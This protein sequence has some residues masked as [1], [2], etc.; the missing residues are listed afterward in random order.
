V[1]SNQDEA[2][3]YHHYNSAHHGLSSAELIISYLHNDLKIRPQS[4]IDVG[5]GLGQWLHIFSSDY[6]CAI[7]GVDGPHVPEEKSFISEKDRVR[8]NLE[9]FVITR[10]VEHYDLVLCLEVAEHLNLSMADAL[11]NKL[12]SLG[13]VLLFSAAIPGQTGENHLNEQP[14]KF[15][16]DKFEERGFLIL[17]PFRKTFWDDSRVN[18]WYAQNL[19]LICKPSVLSE[20]ASK[21]KYEPRLY[22]H[23]RLLDVYRPA[24]S[25]SDSSKN[26]SFYSMAMSLI[27]RLVR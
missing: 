24:S 12:S 20:E 25:S 27:R 7:K 5:C 2:T 26:V 4:V 19:F 15:W 8:C 3:I 17:D 22:V 16:L 1:E 14:H 23:P 10:F 18:W 11:V 9:D 6:G 21:Y 13:D